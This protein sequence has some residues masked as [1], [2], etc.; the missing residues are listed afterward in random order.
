MTD[1]ALSKEQ[2]A[3]WVRDAYNRLYDSPYLHHHPLVAVLLP[4]E[5]QTTHN[6]S[7]NLRRVLLAAIE[8]LKPQSGAPTQSPDWRTYRIFDLRYIEGLSSTEAMEQLAVSKSQF[9]RD[10]A[11]GF[12]HVIALLWEQRNVTAPV[13]GW[14]S[15][16]PASEHET[17]QTETDRLFALAT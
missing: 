6:R 8:A 11:Q 16:W 2:F 9:F 13:P 10:Q 17:V 4:P 7:Q 5:A 15:S 3:K 14:P 12:D 1:Q